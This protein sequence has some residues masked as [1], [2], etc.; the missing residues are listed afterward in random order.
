MDLWPRVDALIERA[1]TVADL[2]HHRLHLYAARRWRSLGRPLSDELAALE[3]GAATL[4]LAT[5]VLA[6][7]VRDAYDGRLVLL[8]GADVAA[9]YPTPELRPS[10]DLDLLVDDADAVYGALLE[11][12]FVVERRPALPADHHHL[13][14]LAWPGL[15]GSVEVHRAPNWPV[16][17]TPPDAEELLEAA[18]GDSAI[19][20][21]VLA[22]HPSHL[23]LVLTAHLWRDDPIQNL[24]HLLDVLLA[25][26]GVDPA[27]LDS[28]LR[29]H[30]LAPLWE[31]TQDVAARVFGDE[32][33]RDSRRVRLLARNLEAVR[34]R[35]VIEARLAEAIAPSYVR[36]PTR[37]AA[38][39]ARTVGHWFRPEPGETW[40]QKVARTLRTL[41]KS[42]SPSS[43]VDRERDRLSEARNAGRTP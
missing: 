15:L 39:T 1:K 22:L 14:N 38:A 35:T 6:G 12:G 28:L 4:R 41:G 2:H 3:R 25:A 7:R 30:R 21:G 33:G 24:G 36:P 42:F 34:D 10:M 31:A 8:K 26:E 29:R 23:M 32:R 43:E 40:R 19:G 37:A 5:P 11:H 20:H 13:P 18:T 16:W 17:L 27:E 9:L